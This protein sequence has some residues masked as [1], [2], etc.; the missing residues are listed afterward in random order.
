ML[1]V[2]PNL[3]LDRN[4][5]LPEMRPGEV[6]R[7]SGATVTAGGKGLNVARVAGLLGARA[8]VV[9]FV[10]GHGGRAVEGLIAEE[11]LAFVPVLIGGEARVMTIVSESDGRVTVLNE[12]GPTITAGEWER[13]A[14]AA[15]RE[16]G[17]HGVLGC[18]GSLPP[19]APP[20]AYARLVRL[21]RERG[22]V[23][24]VDASGDQLAHALRAGPDVVLPNVHEASAALEALGDA[25]VHD[26]RGERWGASVEIDDAAGARAQ[27]ERAAAALVARG[28]SAAIV[29][30]GAAGAALFS[31]SGAAVWISAPL[32]T[33]VNPIGAGDAFTAGLCAALERGVPLMEAAVEGTAAAAASVE[34]ALP[35]RLDPARMRALIPL[36]ART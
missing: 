30:A 21:A 7:F 34:M 31:D 35:G 11:G 10:G 24:V 28:A 16:L 19:G 33:S 27:A 13:L 6:F 36:V 22:L 25:A 8:V 5:T 1:I 4:V 17:G 18:T 15:A 14:E 3:G 29:T 12:P 26:G 20:D 23:T 2:S 32:V 9:G